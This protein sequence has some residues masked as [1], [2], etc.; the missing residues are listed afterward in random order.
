LRVIFETTAHIPPHFRLR[1]DDGTHDCAVKWRKER[2]LGVEFT[3][4]RAS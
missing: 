3:D 1:L 2:V 4:V